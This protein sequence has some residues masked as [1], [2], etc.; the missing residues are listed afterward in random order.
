[1]QRRVA[2]ARVARLG[3]TGPGGG[4][5]LVPCCFV[6]D[7]DTV[8]T[9]IDG[10]P[11]STLLLRRLENLARSPRVSLLVDHYEEDWS[12]LWWVRLDGEAEVVPDGPSRDRAVRLL[13][14]KYA[15]YRSLEIVGPTV[16]IAVDTWRAWP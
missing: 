5:H 11:K 7:G 9:G 2:E 15:Q 1:M 14:G 4:P 8:H 12:R 10:K 16:T 6:L 3:T 13:T